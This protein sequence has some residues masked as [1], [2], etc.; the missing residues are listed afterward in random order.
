MRGVPSAALPVGH[1][2]R[3]GYRLAELRRIVQRHEPA[4]AAAAGE[5]LALEALPA[6]KSVDQARLEH[7]AKV[8]AAAA[9]AAAAAVAAAVGE[10]RRAA[11]QSAAADAVTDGTFSECKLTTPTTTATTTTTATFTVTTDRRSLM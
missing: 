4:V 9:A 7:S 6:W 11:S 10:E 3:F 1:K 2:V 5:Q 8:D